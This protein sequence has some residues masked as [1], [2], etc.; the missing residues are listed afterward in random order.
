MRTA[1]LGSETQAAGRISG[2][3]LVYKPRTHENLDDY[4][5]VIRKTRGY[6]SY[7]EVSEVSLLLN[8]PPKHPG[9]RCECCGKPM[10]VYYETIERTCEERVD[11]A[12]TREVEYTGKVALRGYAPF[13]TLT[14]ALRFA[15][16]SFRAGYRMV[17]K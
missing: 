12:H 10:P 11:D 15:K 17:R 4:A 1:P 13:C 9:D 2:G 7:R 5:K 6:G 16:A 3:S 14:C 8:L